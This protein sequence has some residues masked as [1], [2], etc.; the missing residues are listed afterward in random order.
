MQIEYAMNAVKNGPPSVGLKG[1]LKCFFLN[2]LFIHIIPAKDC[3]VLATENKQSMLYL[4][5]NKID[6]ITEHIGTV[7]SGMGPDNR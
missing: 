5:E 2:S 4:P 6:K 7:Y 1:F 3:V